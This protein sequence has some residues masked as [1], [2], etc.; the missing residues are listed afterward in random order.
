MEMN[1]LCIAMGFF[2]AQNSAAQ[3]NVKSHFV[4]LATTLFYKAVC[5]KQAEAS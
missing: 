5:E 1:K 2:P 3:I 4:K